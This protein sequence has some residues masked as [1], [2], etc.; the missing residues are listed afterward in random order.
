MEV[1][2]G[3]LE[4]SV[5][6]E[7][8]GVV[9]IARR[10]G[11]ERLVGQA[12]GRRGL[13]LNLLGRYDEALAAFDQAIAIGR[14]FQD[15][16]SLQRAYQN[17][18]LTLYALGQNELAI[19]RFQQATAAGVQSASAGSAMLTETAQAF[20]AFI[21]G[22]WVAAREHLRGL[23]GEWSAGDGSS[24]SGLSRRTTEGMVFIAA[25]DFLETGSNYSVER[26]KYFDRLARDIGNSQLAAHATVWLCLNDLW[27]DR[28]DEVIKRI[29]E[30]TLHW[31]GSV[32]GMFVSTILLALANVRK[33][34]AEDALRLL[35]TA[36]P[37][38]RT[39]PEQSLALYARGAALRGLGRE[40]EAV[41][42]LREAIE[43][44][45]GLNRLFQAMA[46]EEL[47]AAYGDQDRPDDAQTIYQA[48]LEQYQDMGAGPSAFRVRAALETYTS[49]ERGRNAHLY[50]RC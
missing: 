12:E 15:L 38:P 45:G 14:K 11:A 31:P 2:P 8:A 37:G 32:P 13:A 3:P 34:R 23:A 5:V 17:A 21:N 16:D 43:R 44:L 35:E 33:G 22:D 24:A 19:Q 28:A 46:Q 26:I 36:E 29:E 20:E 7:P 50:H 4:D 1:W 42:A 10:V 49:E 41:T 9:T 30:S 18:G 40:E 48:A 47:A 6:A 27:S 25:L 39:H